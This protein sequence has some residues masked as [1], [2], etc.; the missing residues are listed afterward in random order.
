MDLLASFGLGVVV[1]VSTDVDDLFLLMGFF[2]DPRIHTSS[3]IIGQYLGIATLIAASILIS[4]VAFVLDPAYVGLLGIL[5]ILVGIKSLVGLWRGDDEEEAVPK[6][7]IGVLPQILSVVSV[8]VANGGDN[9]STYVPLFATQ[10]GVHT[11]ATS[12]SMLMMT[13]VWLLLA[14]WLVNHPTIGAPIRRYS[15][16]I[17][18]FVLIGLGVYILYRAGSFGLLWH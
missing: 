2:A 7:G 6:T 16:R 4:L 14:H 10:S 5:P 17:V 11:A 12:A 15:P 13:A 8:T 1:F 9:V 18:P 3:V